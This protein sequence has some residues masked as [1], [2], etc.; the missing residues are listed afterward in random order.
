[1]HR[2]F[3]SAE[4]SWL[5]NIFQKTDYSVMWCINLDDVRVWCLRVIVISV[6]N[7][8]QI[9]IL[10]RSWWLQHLT[11]HLHYRTALSLLHHRREISQSHQIN[12]AFLLF[13]V[14][15]KN[16]EEDSQRYSQRYRLYSG[17]GHSMRWGNITGVFC[18][19]VCWRKNC[20]GLY[21]YIYGA[22]LYL[23]VLNVQ[24]KQQI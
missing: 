9:S 2:D 11:Y 21:R 10:H 16:L 7:V 19:L 17:P 24:D 5:D 13:T 14:W 20:E 8:C 3:I 22:T 6:Q 15:I 23:P 1:M 18:Q 4:I 12:Q